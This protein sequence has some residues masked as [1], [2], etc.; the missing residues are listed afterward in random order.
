MEEIPTNSIS[1]NK[2]NLKTIKLNKRCFPK[3]FN[4]SK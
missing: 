4:V 1:P 2:G 3:I